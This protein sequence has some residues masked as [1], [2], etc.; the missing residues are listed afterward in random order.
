MVCPPKEVNGGTFSTNEALNLLR[1]CTK[2]NGHLN[3]TNF[4]VQIDFSVFNC[5]QEIT[6]YFGI[7]NN[8]ELTTVSG[9][10][11]LETVGNLG[12]YFG[13]N[14]NGKLTTISGFGNLETV[15]N[16]GGYFEID[17]NAELTTVSGFGN[18]QTVGGSFDIYNNGSGVVL[19]LGVTVALTIHDAFGSFTTGPTKGITGALTLEG[20]AADKKISISQAIIDNMTN[21]PNFTLTPPTPGVTLINVDIMVCAP[22]EVNGGT[23]TSNAALN[24]LR[25]CTKINGSIHLTN[26]NTEQID[27]SVFNCLQEITGSLTIGTNSGLT[28]ISGFGKLQSVGSFIKINPN[29][30]LTTISGFGVLGTVGGY[31]EIRNN[32]ILTTIPDFGVLATVNGYFSIYNNNILPTVSGF[33][34]LAT[35]NGYV[36]IYN[37]SLLTTLSG[38]GNL[39]SIGASCTILNNDLL[40]TISGFGNLVSIGGGLFIYDNSSVVIPANGIVLTIHAFGNFRTIPKSINS[41]NVRGLSENQKISISLAIRSNMVAAVLT[42]PI[43]NF[44]VVT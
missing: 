30:D 23:F 1:G 9:F 24:L 20:P 13:I 33:G 40:T 10:G 4:E 36:S 6:G 41:L 12:G 3:L 11:N 25:D 37:N 15:G 17:N 38:F 32:N 26:F 14:S 22:K 18:L 16:L 19:E 28:T 8:A 44:I 35:V 43:L 21:I 5:L 39:V 31:F 7:D 2:I 29:A 34:V 27:F 42:T